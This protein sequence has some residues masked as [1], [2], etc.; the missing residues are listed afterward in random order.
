MH[1]V[2]SVTMR[3]PI[4]EHYQRAVLDPTKLG[5]RGGLSSATQHA[6]DKA[7]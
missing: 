6:T 4:V 5:G 2:G 3:Q 7:T 1:V